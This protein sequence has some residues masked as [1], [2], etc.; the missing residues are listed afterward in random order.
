MKNKLVTLLALTALPISAMEKNHNEISLWHSLPSKIRNQI[1]VEIS[2]SENT[3]VAVDTLK[4]IVATNSNFITSEEITNYLDAVGEKFPGQEIRIANLLR[5]PIGDTW[6]NAKRKI[7]YNRIST[8]KEDKTEGEKAVVKDL[9]NK[10]KFQQ[11]RKWV[12]KGYN[13]ITVK[14]YAIGISGCGLYWTGAY[15]A[16]ILHE[17]GADISQ[18][19]LN[20][21]EPE[22]GLIDVTGNSDLL[23]TLYLE[24]TE[25]HL[26][27]N[28]IHFKI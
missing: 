27:K 16:C 22:H 11:L 24:A 3:Q 23:E 2:D 10:D 6:L 28:N 20:A 13:P 25:E 9:I 4:N 18:Y 7:S 19:I 15:M 12:E 17:Y 5:R 26:G 8:T 14:H 21:D 1:L